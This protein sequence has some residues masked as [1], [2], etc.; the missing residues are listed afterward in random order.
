V[1]K[2]LHDK[3]RLE[4]LLGSGGMAAVYEATH[5]N[6]KRAAIK[7][8]HAELSV[9]DHFRTRF[10]REGY[11]ANTVG[12][13]GA[14][15]VLDDEVAED[16]SVFLVMELLEGETFGERWE[17]CDKRLPAHEVL[18]IV[19]KLLDV[20]AAAHAKGI[21]HRDIKPDNVFLTNDGQV[22]VLDFGVA[23]LRELSGANVTMSGMTMGTP[24]FM[25]PEQARGRSN[26][27]DA[28]T[29][30]WAVGATMFTVLTGRFVH[31]AETGNEVMLMAM[32]KRAPLLAAVAPALPADLCAI[33]DRALEYERERRFASAAEMQSAVRRVASTI[34][35]TVIAGALNVTVSVGPH[36]TADAMTTTVL[37]DSEQRFAREMLEKP[38]ESTASP[39][40]AS[41]ITP[42]KRSRRGV[43][44]VA[45]V[46]VALA[47]LGVRSLLVDHAPPPII[48][49]VE[50]SAASVAEAS[51]GAL[52]P[53]PSASIAFPM[54]TASALPIASAASSAR[55]I[56]PK[57]A[58]PR[59]RASA[60]SAIAAPLAPTASN[61]APAS[62]VAPPVAPPEDPHDRRR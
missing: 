31:R 1:G 26:E 44:L 62:P 9:H 61:S 24:A 28:R 15:S 30:L 41:V 21:V 38:A 50:A 52:P 56:S 10:L 33:V 32:M 42:A 20:L 54:E 6:G 22:K 4:S 5:R 49:T 58:L 36:E 43:A 11:L 40:A 8:L 13:P 7:V 16:G 39:T 48:A 23:R 14:V 59:P 45:I 3:W 46:L 35:R 18:T 47:A 51:R 25:P 12:H 27:I 37:S 55:E 53:V 60:T 19:D 57:K 17:R 2:L 29:D 34:D